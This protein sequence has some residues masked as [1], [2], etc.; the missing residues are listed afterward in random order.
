KRARQPRLRIRE[1]IERVQAALTRCAVPRSL[2]AM[3]STSPA[4]AHEPFSR[5]LGSLLAHEHGPLT[6][7]RVIE[8]TE[9]R[10][11]YLVLIVFSLPFVAWVSVPGMSTVLGP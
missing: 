10:G 5:S 8:G 4:P 3:Q 7:N 9:G 6:A 2:P 11:L 1:Q